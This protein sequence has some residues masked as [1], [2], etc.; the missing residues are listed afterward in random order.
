MSL[1]ICPEFTKNSA[2][3]P[4]KHIAS[5]EVNKFIKTF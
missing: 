2:K 1:L 5:S 3:Y 4:D